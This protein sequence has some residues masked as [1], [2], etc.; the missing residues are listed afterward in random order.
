MLKRAVRLLRDAGAMTRC[1][2][3]LSTQLEDAA[4]GLM[5]QRGELERKLIEAVGED[6]SVEGVHVRDVYFGTMEDVDA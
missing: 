2:E 1:Y 6:G 4:N 5:A 3:R